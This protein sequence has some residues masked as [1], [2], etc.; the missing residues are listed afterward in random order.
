M[1]TLT[2]EHRIAVEREIARRSLA[3]FAK[4]A[5][6]ILEPSTPLKWGWALDAI[7]AHLE[8]VTDGRIPRLLMNV[9]PG[10][11]KSLLTGVIWPAWEWGP[12][13]KP[14]MRFLGTA[15]K[16]DLAIRDAMK[17]R[18]LIASAWYQARWPIALVSD[19]N[20]KSKFENDST[21]FREAMAFT[22]M[23]GSRGDR[24]ILDD[25][26][27]ADDGNSDA[28]LRAA[29][30][31][32][33]EALPTRVNND[34][35]AIVVIM[36]R[37]SDRD[38]SGVILDRGL[39]YVHL[40]LPMRFEPSRRCV[41]PIFT[42]PRQTDGELVFP[43][44]FG[45]AQVADLERTM[46][47]YASAGQL[48]QRPAP[49]G[50]G[51]FK[52]AWLRYWQHEPQLE[53]R[54]IYA[55][56]AQKTGEENDYS[57][58]QCWGRSTTGQAVLLDMIRGKWEAPELMVQARSFWLKH[59]AI[60]GSPLRAIKVEDKVSGTGLIQTLRREGVPILPIQRNRDKVSRA[61]D[62][63]PFMES[64]NVLL[65]EAAPWLSDFLGELTGFPFGAHDDQ[66]DPML[67]AI[68]DVQSLPAMTRTITPL[69]P[70][71]ALGANRSF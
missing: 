26:L 27:S 62:G 36:Q 30:L 12:K 8:A 55:D 71:V 4:M 25:P 24:I 51:I 50:G 48:Q 3:S 14:G 44:R 53:W 65:P 49:R 67:D 52:A 58:F 10:M 23:T 31:T 57:V 54:T 61:H 70:R 35:S 46:G 19:Q 11:M 60:S 42:D 45:E 7:C 33:T 1:L 28:A 22:S 5:W 43:E 66:I 64:G 38:T 40:C 69:M 34:Q 15:H 59:N 9:P 41:T 13:G 17:C 32:F 18:R 21:G 29:E 20:A 39:P 16:Q 37:L 6:A 2:N 63:S 47:S 56:T 68:K